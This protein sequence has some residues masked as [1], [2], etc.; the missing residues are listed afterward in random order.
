MNLT[1]QI[2][3]GKEAQAKFQKLGQRLFIFTAAMDDIGNKLED[4][5]SNA[6]FLSQGGVYGN[7]WKRLQHATVVDKAKHYSGRPPEFRTGKMQSGF[8][9]TSTSSSVKIYNRMPYFKYQQLGTS[10]LPARQMIGVNSE[11]MK[12]IRDIIEKDVNKKLRSV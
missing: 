12:M 3:G 2:K 11:V 7:K 9:H 4:Y 5:Y 6:A 10:R 8:R 1:I